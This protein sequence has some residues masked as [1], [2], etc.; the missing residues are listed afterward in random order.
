M[1]LVFDIKNR[2]RASIKGPLRERN[3]AGLGKTIVKISY[4]TNTKEDDQGPFHMPYPKG[5]IQ[6]LKRSISLK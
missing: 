3:A 2:P 5:K 1:I 4:V 6:I